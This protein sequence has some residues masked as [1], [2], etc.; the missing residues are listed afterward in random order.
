MKIFKRSVAG[1][2]AA[3]MSVSVCVSCNSDSIVSRLKEN[4]GLRVGYC[5][6]SE[7]DD[8]PFVI[9]SKNAAGVEGIT[10]EPASDAANSIGV[11]VSFSRLDLSSAY[12]SLL[13][14]SVDCLWNCPPPSKKL[15]SSVRTIGTGLY[16]R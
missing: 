4:G 8:A 1:I 6:S 3:V 5:S 13:Q 12:D 9:E 11:G 10:G 7:T 14:G 16:Y 2:I 15:V